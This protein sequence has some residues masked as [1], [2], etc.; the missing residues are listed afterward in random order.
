ME[1][2]EFFEGFIQEISN[3]NNLYLS[4]VFLLG[5]IIFLATLGYYWYRI[6]SYNKLNRELKDI[7]KE[8][9]EVHRRIYNI[10]NWFTNEKNKPSKRLRKIW[11]HYHT[12]YQSDNNTTIPDP[13]YYFNTDELINKAGARKF[14]ETIPAMFVS[15][16]LLGTFIGIVLGISDLNT[17]SGSEALASGIDTLLNGMAFAFYSSVLG[18]II[19]IIYQL[20]DRL[21]FYRSLQKGADNLLIELDKT[22]PIETESSMLEKMVAAQETQISDMK[23]FF[24]DQLLPGL[25]S[26]ISDSVTDAISPQLE[27]SNEILD[28]VANNTL[29]SQ[30]ESM[31]Q[32]VDHFV[33]S[34]NELTGN[35]IEALGNALSKTVEWQEKV[36][37]ELSDLVGELSHVATEQAEMASK[38]TTLSEQMNTYT[39]K[40]ANYQQELSTTTSELGA[41]TEE[42]TNLLTEMNKIYEQI[43]VKQNEDNEQLELRLTTLNQTVEKIT[44]LSN[45]FTDVNA[46]MKTTLDSLIQ[47]TTGLRETNEQNKSLTDSLM[48]QHDLSNQWSVKTQSL[49]EDVTENI[50]ISEK[51]QST[52]QSM[53]ELVSEEKTDL[54]QLQTQYSDTITSSVESLSQFWNDHNNYISNSQAQLARLNENL[55]DSM[56][57][58]AEHMHRGVQGTFEEF[59]KELKKAVE[60]LERGVSSI[61]MVVEALEEDVGGLDGHLK[62]LNESLSTITDNRVVA[63]E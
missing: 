41:V 38:T 50:T 27:K 45:S 19:S 36:H 33:T 3:G 21:F 26:G 52:I 5:L 35:Q 48:K 4:T 47:T 30:S 34:L 14:I 2:I 22:I 6:N 13:L 40:L 18:I 59:D 46:E 11:E 12:E 58:F 20:I 63:N 17:N 55:G 28:K 54:K 43:T 37:G 61:R 57:S 32:M 24:T 25:T 51:V 15:L 53:Y 42:N 56:E 1:L 8:E 7:R 62:K 31:N 49:L 39:D 16:G 60:Y 29:E 10:D 23:S 44:N 9:Q